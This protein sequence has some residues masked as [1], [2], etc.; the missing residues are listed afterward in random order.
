M[1]QVKFT[2][3]TTRTQFLINFVNM[4]IEL[5]SL[6]FVR[7]TL[8]ILGPNY[9]TLHKKW[10]FLLRIFSVN[11]I[12][13]AESCGFTFTEDILNGKLHFFENKCFLFRDEPFLLA[14]VKNRNLYD[15]L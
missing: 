7:T 5:V 1:N 11:V 13:S 15:L 12:K 6:I 9:E 4:L 14:L 3:P 8:Q 2:K 10:A